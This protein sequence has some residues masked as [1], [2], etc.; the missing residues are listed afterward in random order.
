MDV[1]GSEFI[2]HYIVLNADTGV[3]FLYPEVGLAISPLNRCRRSL[4]CTRRQVLVLTDAD[5][6]DTVQL[7]N[8]LK[9]KPYLVAIPMYEPLT[10]VVQVDRKQH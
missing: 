10:R 3:L 6:E 8:K 1:P 5:R 9:Q 4:A 2:N 7:Q